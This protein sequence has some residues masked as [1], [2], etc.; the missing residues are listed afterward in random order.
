M[1][2]YIAYCPLTETVRAAVTSPRPSAFRFPLLFV[3]SA[4][5]FTHRCYSH[6]EDSASAMAL[7]KP[8]IWHSALTLSVRLRPRGDTLLC[9]NCICNAHTRAKASCIHQVHTY[10][11][12]QGSHSKRTRIKYISE[13]YFKLVNSQLTCI[14]FHYIERTKN[15]LF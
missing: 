13:K 14:V 12:A 5:R 2:V 4:P 3:A 11:N 10:I 9:R 1:N 8:I 6:T 7:S 15:L